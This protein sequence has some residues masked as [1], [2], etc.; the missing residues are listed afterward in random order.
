MNRNHISQSILPVL[1]LEINRACHVDKERCKGKAD[2]TCIRTCR[3]RG[4]RFWISYKYSSI[5]HLCAT[6]RFHCCIIGTFVF[7][8]AYVNQITKLQFL[9]AIF[10]T[11]ETFYYKYV[12]NFS[13]ISKQIHTA[14]LS[15]YNLKICISLSGK[16]FRFPHGCA[17]L[18]N[19]NWTLFK[20]DRM[21]CNAD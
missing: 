7:Y 15:R 13:T 1:D 2:E 9:F 17:A 11:E 21:R 19:I 12:E 14:I 10:R 6:V 18:I 5:A 16:Y 8:I 4:K 20:R 3:C